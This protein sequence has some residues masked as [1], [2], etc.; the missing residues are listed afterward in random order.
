MSGPR[1]VIVPDGFKGSLGAAGVAAALAAGIREARPEVVVDEVPMADGGD[2]TL[3][4]FA[5]AGDATGL[6]TPT[7]NNDRVTGP[8]GDP[9]DADWLLFPEA[10]VALIEMASA[11]GLVLVPE[12][13]RDPLVTTTRGT[14]ELARLAL[15][16]GARRVLVTV[17]GSATNDGGTGFARALGWRFL[18]ADGA[19]VEDGGAGLERI[20]SIDAT[21]LTGPAKAIATGARDAPRIVCLAD[22][23]NPLCGPEGAAATYGPQKGADEAT[24]ARL[25]A[26][27]GNLAAVASHDLAGLSATPR[28][29][30][31]DVATLPGAGAAGG[32]AAGLVWFADAEIRPG[33]V[34]LIAALGLA[35]RLRGASLV[36]TGEGRIDFQTPRG[37]V[38]AAV[39]RTAR[40]AD[41]PVW[42]VAGTSG[43]GWEEVRT[44]CGVSRIE[45][46]ARPGDAD[47]ERAAVADPAPRLRAL[48]ARLAPDVP[49]SDETT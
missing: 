30:P 39:A 46:I 13:R 33:A 8:L 49:T 29:P 24:V 34:E 6:G 5:A 35:D 47:D 20:A 3:E 42:V 23:D 37:K 31:G 17:G 32:L 48:G 1:V 26:G 7:R 18:D 10:G 27:L 40:E 45:T 19:V 36:I 2:G 12:D 38:V 21:A 16:A 44:A 41:V 11:S 15:E 9:V 4:A 22:V 43:R 14:G 28:T 25:D